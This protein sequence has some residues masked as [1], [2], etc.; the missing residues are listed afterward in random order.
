LCTHQQSIHICTSSFG[1]LFSEHALRLLST[2][3]A[4][5]LAPLSAEQQSPLV[6]YE[7]Q[8]RSPKLKLLYVESKKHQLMT[9]SFSWHHLSPPWHQPLPQ[10]LL[11]F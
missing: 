8:Q 1:Q 4:S 5:S 3:L 2:I 10:L 7:Q 6:S 11:P 9:F